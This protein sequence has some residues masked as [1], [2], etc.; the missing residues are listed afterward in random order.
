MTRSLTYLACGMLLA[1]CYAPT[2]L[3]PAQAP[4]APPPAPA[5]AMPLQPN[6]SYVW[7]P[8]SYTWNAT[9]RMYVWVPGHWT[10]PP[11]GQ[12]W[13]PGHWET[14]STGQIWVEGHWRPQ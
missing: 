2:Q 3:G 11:P 12:V 7:V 14:A 13:V 9:T 8:G 10:V 5:E 1:G 6:P 4:P